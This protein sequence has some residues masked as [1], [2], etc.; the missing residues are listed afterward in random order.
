MKSD[1]T[2]T[3]ERLVTHFFSDISIEHLARYS[4]ATQFV[5][6]NIVIDLA[7]GEGYGAYILSQTAKSVIGVDI[8]QACIEHARTKYKNENLE[9]IISPVNNLPIRDAFADVIVSFETIEHLNEQE[10]M[11]HE[12]SRILKNTGILIISTPDKYNYTV[13]RNFINPFHKKELFI[14]EFETLVKTFFKYTEFFKQKTYFNTLISP[15]AN[16]EFRLEE[17]AGSF[18]KIEKHPTIQEPM[19]W[20]AVCSNSQLPVTHAVVFNGEAVLQ[21]KLNEIRNEFRNSWTY[22]IGNIFTWPYKKLRKSNKR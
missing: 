4:F 9:F 14:D 20:I 18:E 7:C 1:L 12:I 21:Q 3:G 22:K 2:W 6:N 16:K 5:Q 17:H 11:L 15:S 13:K 8:D 19:Y 10:A